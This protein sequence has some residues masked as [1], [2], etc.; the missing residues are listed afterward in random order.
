M[1]RY[2]AQKGA[3]GTYSAW[4]GVTQ[5]TQ[6]CPYQSP[7]ENRENVLVKQQQKMYSNTKSAFVNMLHQ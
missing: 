5:G 3:S 7:M 6:Q 2:R 4:N 1:G